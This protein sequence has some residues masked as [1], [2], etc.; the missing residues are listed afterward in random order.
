MMVGDAEQRRGGEAKV[1]VDLHFLQRPARLATRF[2]VTR[3]PT[4]LPALCRYWCRCN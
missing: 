2:D 4:C 1:V 3:P